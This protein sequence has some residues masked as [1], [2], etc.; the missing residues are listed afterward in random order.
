MS[1]QAVQ[2]EEGDVLLDLHGGSQ[3]V[4]RGGGW[5]IVM[6]DGADYPVDGL[7]W[8]I[9]DRLTEIVKPLRTHK[10]GNTVYREDGFLSVNGGEWRMSA[11]NE[12]QLD[13]FTSWG[14]A[15]PAHM[16]EK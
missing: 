14:W 6:R 16:E 8:Q 4:A 2:F 15:I 3:L 13:L 12:N 11:G 9:L 5:L 1:K 7:S 10:I